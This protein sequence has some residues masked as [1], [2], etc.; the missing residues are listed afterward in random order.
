MTTCIIDISKWDDVHSFHAAKDAGYVFCWCRA[1]R[2]DRVD[3]R[4]LGFM[5]RLHTLEPEGQMVGAYH[6][7]TAGDGAT[8]AK[9]FLNTLNHI[10]EETGQI[11]K[12]RCLDLERN[13]SGEDM[14][15]FDAEKFVKEVYSVTGNYPVLYGGSKLKE[16]DISLNSPLLNCKLWLAHYKSQYVLPK[17]W[18][19]LFMWQ[20]TG[21]G[22]G[23][24]PHIVPGIGVCD[25]SKFNG[26][27]EDLREWYATLK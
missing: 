4:V 26:S 24:T 22:E 8:Q 18:D 7:G 13:P 17:R 11:V 5:K 10:K 25:I 1:T 16:M 2:G 21:D 6:F 15:L 3:S 12:A 19:D 27:I 14:S 20:F 23:P 9:F